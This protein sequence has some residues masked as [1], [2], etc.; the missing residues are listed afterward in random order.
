MLQLFCAGQGCES[1]A[2]RTTDGP[3]FVGLNAVNRGG[4]WVLVEDQRIG[5][6]PKF[7]HLVGRDISN[8]KNRAD[9]SAV[10]DN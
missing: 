5:V 8:I 3:Q 10:L 4:R 7:A 6:H 9:F 2:V 1:L